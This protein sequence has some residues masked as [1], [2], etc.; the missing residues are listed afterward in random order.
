[1]DDAG[2]GQVLGLGHDLVDLKEFGRQLAM[3]GTRMTSLFSPRERRQAQQRAQ[4]KHDDTAAHLAARWAGK[5]SVLKAWSQA[6]GPEPSPYGLDDFPWSGVE[7]LDDGRGR[8]SVNL[9]SSVRAKLHESLPLTDSQVDQVELLWH[10]ALSHDGPVA[11]AVV[12]L[13]RCV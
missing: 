7:I 9:K 12:L 1:M 6:L 10:I 8:P 13:C 2:F 3:P 11:S 4:L 5:E